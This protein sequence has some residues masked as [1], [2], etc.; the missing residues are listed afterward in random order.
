MNESKTGVAARRFGMTSVLLVCL[1][2][3]SLS[4]ASI[5]KGVGWGGRVG[6]ELLRVYVLLW[7][8]SMPT[9]LIAAACFFTDRWRHRSDDPPRKTRSWVIAGVVASSIIS[10]LSAAI[11]ASF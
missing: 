2:I 11:L 8:L 3:L 7:V 5:S 4:L 9:A 6:G 10:A 1:A